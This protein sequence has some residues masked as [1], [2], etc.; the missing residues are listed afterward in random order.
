MSSQRV[1]HTL[2]LWL[3]LC[4]IASGCSDPKR[5]Q[6]G[7][8]VLF[9]DSGVPRGCVQPLFPENEPDM[10][11]APVFESIAVQPGQSVDAEITVN[12]PTRNVTVE[13]SNAWSDVPPIGT[14]DAQTSGD[15]VVPISFATMDEQQ[16]RY[17]LRVTLCGADCNEQMVVF[18]LDPDINANYERMV[19]ERGTIIKA[20]STCI[21][22]S[23]ILIQ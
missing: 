19:V 15:E 21:R 2:T 7:P 18:G 10:L 20:E 6:N 17:Y 8:V 12:A 23:S 11:S 1:R 4:V 16:G 22:P 9:P 14:Q 5:T 3:S 13:L